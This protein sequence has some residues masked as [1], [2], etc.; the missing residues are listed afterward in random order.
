MTSEM[1]VNKIKFFKKS[2]EASKKSGIEKKVNEIMGQ[3]MNHS[4]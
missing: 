3:G 1:W 4:V 2:Y